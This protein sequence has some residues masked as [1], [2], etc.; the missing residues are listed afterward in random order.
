MCRISPHTWDY[1]LYALWVTDS[2]NLVVLLRS[3]DSYSWLYQKD[4]RKIDIYI[5]IRKSAKGETL[6]VMFQM[7]MITLL[8][9]KIHQAT[10]DKKSHH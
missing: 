4:H 9:Q 5:Y 8:N 3:Y 2:G 1:S 7:K 10:H 6:Y